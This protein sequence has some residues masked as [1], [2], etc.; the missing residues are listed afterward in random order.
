MEITNGGRPAY[1]VNVEV[2]LHSGDRWLM[3]KRSDLEAHA[4]GVLSA[5]GGK[6]EPDGADPIVG[7]LE[8]TAVREA[9]EEV[10]VDLAGADLSYVESCYFAAD[11]GDPVI[12]IV[13]SGELPPGAEPHAASADEVAAV[14]LM[15][16]QQ[17]LADADCPPWTRR[18]LGKAERLR[19]DRP[20]PVR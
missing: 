10:G 4:P 14:R 19:K 2:Y 3:I 17:I 6:A 1:V 9:L 16:V 13:F 8:Q 20:S 18:A 5:P 11:D 7:I 12:N 15:T